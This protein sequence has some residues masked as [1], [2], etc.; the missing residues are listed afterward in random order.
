VPAIKAVLA[1]R[2]LCPPYVAAPLLACTEAERRDLI[3]LL[4]DEEPHLLTRRN[5]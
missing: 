5:S 4:G 2:G 1:D 3:A